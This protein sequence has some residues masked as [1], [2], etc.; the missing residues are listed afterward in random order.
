MLKLEA[1]TFSEYTWNIFN[2]KF[3]G[4]YDV[5]NYVLVGCLG[6]SYIDRRVKKILFF[7]IICYM[8][9]FEI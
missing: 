5:L 8:L 2:V 7:L 6:H 9:D 4:T 3:Q 1:S